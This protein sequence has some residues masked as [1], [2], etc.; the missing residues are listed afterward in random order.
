MR[1]PCVF[2]VIG[3]FGHHHVRIPIGFSF[4]L[5]PAAAFRVGIDPAVSAD[6]F[7]PIPDGPSDNLPAGREAEGELVFR[8]DEDS[9]RGDRLLTAAASTQP[10]A[11]RTEGD[12]SSVTGQRVDGLAV[13][14]PFFE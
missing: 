5:S 11:V 12:V 7:V 3:F 4:G 10:A 1:F 8:V 6:G 14:G 2:Y 13:W 9:T